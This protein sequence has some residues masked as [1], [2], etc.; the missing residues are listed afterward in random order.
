MNITDKEL[1][2]RL[3]WIP[4]EKQTISEPS[5]TEFDFEIFKNIIIEYIKKISADKVAVLLSGGI[6]SS[7]MAWFAAEAEKY[8]VCYTVAYERDKGE[9]LNASKT[10]KLLGLP[11]AIVRVSEQD[12]LDIFGDYVKACPKIHAE[13]SGIPLALLMKQVYK[14]GIDDAILGDG[15]DDLFGGYMFFD[16]LVKYEQDLPE[17]VTSNMNRALTLYGLSRDI[18]RDDEYYYITGEKGHPEFNNFI[19]NHMASYFKHDKLTQGLSDYDIDNWLNQAMVPKVETGANMYKIN[20]HT[21]IL[22]DEIQDMANSLTDEWRVNKKALRKGMIGSPLDMIMHIPKLGFKPPFMFWLTRDPWKEYL[23]DNLD[24]YNIQYIS[25]KL[26]GDFTGSL[27]AF[28][29]LVW[30]TYNKGEWDG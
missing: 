21:P 7:L 25:E 24:N 28:R 6:D 15:G 3:G 1:F 17:R 2:L 27:F 16:K 20:T 10:A 5:N 29:C 13:W 9:E 26:L 4:P 30:E 18:M 22:I 11:H 8:V 12:C 19:I 23:L 14:D